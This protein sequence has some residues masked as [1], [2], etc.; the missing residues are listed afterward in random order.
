MAEETSTT[1]PPAAEPP[2]ANPLAKPAA[3]SASPIGPTIK[4]P[5][6]G[7]GLKPGLKLPPKPASPLKTVAAASPLKPGLKMPAAPALK[8]GLKLPTKPVIRK[9]GSGLTPVRPHL[10]GAAASAPAP[11]AAAPAPAPAPAAAPAPAPA[12]AAPAAAPAAAAKPADAL[13]TLKAVTKNL[14]SLTSPIPQQAILRKTGIIADPSQSLTE[15]QKQAA[16]SKTSR[17]SLADAVGAA[18]V[19][20]DGAPMKTIRIKRPVDLPLDGPGSASAKKATARIVAPPSVASEEPAAPAASAEVSATQRKTLKIT[21]PGGGTVRPAGRFGVKKPG[22]PA[23]PAAAPAPAE[24]AAV[25]DIPD[26]PDIP[27][28]PTNVPAFAAPSAS[29]DTVPD[30]P[31]AVATLGV[32]AQLAACIVMGALAW[33]LYQD[34]TISLF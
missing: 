11:A 7:G 14:K 20:N 3:T 27:A 22:A 9:P 10:P 19:K 21:R 28:M 25:A 26:I 13:D 17:I 1:V 5:V 33:F 32:V 6:I 8:S 16:K 30:V 12:P 34:S 29:G 15:A 18:P 23:A 24:S 2:K 31:P 4:K